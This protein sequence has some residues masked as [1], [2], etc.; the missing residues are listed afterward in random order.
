MLPG[1][2]SNLLEDSSPL[3]SLLT[4]ADK[5]IQ[6]FLSNVVSGIDVERYEDQDAMRRKQQAEWMSLLLS[7]HS[8][9]SDIS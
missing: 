8:R 5:E 3:I 1:S 6:E 9:I 4:Q 2:K 7:L